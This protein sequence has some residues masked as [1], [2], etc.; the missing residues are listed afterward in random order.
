MSHARNIT[1]EAAAVLTAAFNRPAGPEDCEAVDCP[2]CA[3]TTIANL[4][5]ALAAAADALDHAQSVTERSD[6]LIILKAMR[7]AKAVLA[8]IEA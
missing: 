8:K 7:A 2:V 6:H 4:V 1:P 3:K 5:A